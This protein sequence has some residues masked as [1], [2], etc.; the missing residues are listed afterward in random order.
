MPSK[1]KRQ[2]P[3][4]KPTDLTDEP[5]T[6]INPYKV[7]DVEKDATAS[8]IKAA[9]HKA[10]LKSHP[11]KVP[12]AEK[13][14]AHTRFQAVAFAYAILS[15]GRRR[16]RYD[17]T[18][19]TSEALD[20]EADFEWINF[21]RAQFDEVVSAASIE[22]FR[23]EFQGSDEEK[24]AVLAAYIE[25]EGDM[26]RIYEEVMLSDPLEDEERFRKWIDDEI[27]AGRVEAYDAYRKEGKKGRERRMKAAKKEREEAEEYAKELGM[28][29]KL[30]GNGETNGAS[31]KKKAKKGEEDIGG[32]AAL[33]QQRNKER[34]KDFFADL[35]AKYAPKKSKK[36]KSGANEVDEPPE[37]A[38]E[39]K[40]FF[41]DLEAK[42][43]PKKSKK[44]KSGADEVDEPP[45]EAFERTSKRAKKAKA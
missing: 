16:A 18:G 30:F 23:A 39:R 33:I 1:T 34:S 25:G 15:D 41:A 19:R 9:Y 11:D 22:A 24:L 43:A 40:P 31:P 20:D 4:P 27:V 10:A 44:R 13:A 36:R 5:P 7:L 8:Q 6:S 12:D 37:E 2:R 32:L 42:Y 17:A 14:A 21:Y 29:D 26:L 28:H 45:E 38:F 3:E 35:E